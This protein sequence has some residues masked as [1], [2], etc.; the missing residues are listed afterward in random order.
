M[1]GNL[2]DQIQQTNGEPVSRVKLLLRALGV[3]GVTTI[4]FGSLYLGILLLE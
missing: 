3:F 4:L 2:D 1:F